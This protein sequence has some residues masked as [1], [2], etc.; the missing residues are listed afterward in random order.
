M[1]R[2]FL[3]EFD[4]HDQEFIDDPFH[5][6]EEM[7]EKCPV[8]RTEAYGGFWL[9]SRYS[10]VRMALRDWETFTSSVP[11]VTTIPVSFT[12]DF[13]EIPLE[14]D[15]PLHTKYRQLVSPV[16][17]RS[18]MDAM[19]PVVDRVVTDLLD[20]LEPTGEADLVQ[21][22]AIPLTLTVLAE[23]MG[24]PHE[25]KSQWGE[26]VAQIFKGRID[27]RVAADAAAARFMEYVDELIAERRRA[28]R[29][30]LFS[31]LISSEVEG[32]HLTDEEIR[33]FGMLLLVAG[34]ETTASALGNS[35]LY[36]ADKPGDRR[37][38]VDS[39]Q[40][41]PAAVEE[42]LRYLSPVQILGRNAACDVDLVGQH[43]TK[44][45]VVAIS[46]GSANRDAS[47]FEEADKVRLDRRPNPHLAF[48]SGPHT[49]LGAHLA[50]LELRVALT[51]LLQRFPDY[52]VTERAAVQRRP[53]G[54][55]WG[56]WNLPVALTPH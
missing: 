43:I 11:G 29:E 56:V 32:Q 15:P 6:Y 40:M 54:D 44:G 16:F 12:R 10:E 2:N 53:H 26:W 45:D 51:K 35:M 49:C 55:I 28:P 18:R 36:L 38:L 27:D 47:A 1:P 41:I 13:P 8:A 48:G 22:F 25:D 39:P 42:L 50:R 17:S 3:T 7:R 30:D 37:V 46:F 4:H 34:H 20:G 23:F 21:E 5:I 19:E 52:A 14:L 9:L 24:L 33:G 31:M